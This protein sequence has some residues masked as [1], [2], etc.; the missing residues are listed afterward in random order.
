MD[1]EIAYIARYY[2]KNIRSKDIDRS[3]ISLVWPMFRKHED[4]VRKQVNKH[5]VSFAYDD[6]DLIDRVLFVLWY[7]E[8]LIIKTP[9]EVILNEMIELAKRYGDEQSP[10][11]LNGIGHKILTELEEWTVE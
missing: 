4:A 8:F 7:I 3:Y 2:F 1:K 11:L 9:K 5:A 6:M 10:K